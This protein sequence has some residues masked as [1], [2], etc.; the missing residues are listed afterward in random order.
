MMYL[1]EGNDPTATTLFRDVEKDLPV[2]T[3]FNRGWIILQNGRQY[4]RGI[5][6][7]QSRRYTFKW[8]LTLNI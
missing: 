4:H 6:Y 5:N 2:T 7:S 3:G 1:C 8:M